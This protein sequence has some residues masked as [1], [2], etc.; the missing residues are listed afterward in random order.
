MPG[1]PAV[2]VAPDRRD[3]VRILLGRGGDRG[4]ADGAPGERVARG[5]G[6]ARGATPGRRDERGQGAS[7]G[8]A[9]RE[10]RVERRVVDP[11]SV[12][13]APELLPE[14]RERRQ[15]RRGESAA[16]G[17]A[18]VDVDED[19]VAR[20]E[21]A[22]RGA[23]RPPKS[24]RGTERIEDRDPAR[25]R[26]ERGDLPE[27]AIE[28]IVAAR[29]PACVGRLD[30]RGPNL[31]DPRREELRDRAAEV[32]DVAGVDG[33]A[34]DEPVREKPGTPAPEPQEKG[35]ERGAGAGA[36]ALLRGAEAVAR[37]LDRDPRLVQEL[38]RRVVEE[39]AVRH[40]A[41][42]GREAGP[43]PGREERERPADELLRE[44][45]LAPEEDELRPRVARSGHEANGGLEDGLVH[46]AGR[47]APLRAVGAREVAPRREEERHGAGARDERP[48]GRNRE[49]RHFPASARTYGVAASTSST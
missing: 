9:P 7:S 41:H 45:R 43:R 47:A 21:A 48:D 40:D 15:D 16:R 10:A 18:A 17:E 4:G 3:E 33:H 14:G 2:P 1:R 29:V 27:R 23:E 26:R 20:A 13:P 11:R 38:D 6:A 31:A 39:E 49:V 42:V 5:A 44:E 35:A 19:D 36:A 46:L 32:G 30:R 22:R 25:A 12:E 8:L 37:E 34:C 28:E 24:R